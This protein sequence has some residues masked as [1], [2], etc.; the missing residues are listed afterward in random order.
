MCRTFRIKICGD[1]VLNIFVGY[2]TT[3]NT[4]ENM[5]T[6]KYLIDSFQTNKKLL[7]DAFIID[8]VYN[9]AANDFIVAQTQFGKML[10]DNAFN[11]SKYTMELMFPST[12]KKSK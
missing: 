3:H 11:L 5:D 12:T 8:R 1:L 2:S 9:K 4:E 10:V 6:V 7:T